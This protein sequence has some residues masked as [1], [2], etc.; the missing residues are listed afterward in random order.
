MLPLRVPGSVQAAEVLRTEILTEK[1]REVGG[2]TA[3]LE[4][5]EGALDRLFG[6]PGQLLNCGRVHALGVQRKNQVGLA[7]GCP[8]RLGEIAVV[9]D[10][11]AG[12]L[13]SRLRFFQRQAYPGRSMEG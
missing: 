13:G 8:A 6:S 12:H 5:G 9:S 2:L 11:V 3:L 7:L 10:D 4:V 1:W